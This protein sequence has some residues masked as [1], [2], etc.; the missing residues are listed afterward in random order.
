MGS[1]V[2]CRGWQPVLSATHRLEEG[3]HPPWIDICGQQHAQ[4]FHVRLALELTAVAQGAQ[5]TRAFDA[6]GHHAREV[7]RDRD[8]Q[9]AGR[10]V[11]QQKTRRVAMQHV[12]D[13]VR[14]HS[15][16]LLRRP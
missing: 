16:Q 9:E 14:E 1:E 3:D 6:V 2:A 13:L 15:G 5:H 10:G 4:P 7:A 12:L 8:Q 11:L